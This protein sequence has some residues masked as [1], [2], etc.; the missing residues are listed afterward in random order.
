MCECPSVC[1]LCVCVSDVTHRIGLQDCRIGL[2]AIFKKDRVLGFL[3]C[4]CKCV[5]FT[6]LFRFVGW[7][8]MI[9]MMQ[10]IWDVT[11]RIG[12]QDC[13]I[14]LR[15]IFKKDRVLGFLWCFCKCVFSLCCSVLLDDCRWLMSRSRLQDCTIALRAIFWSFLGVIV[16][17]R[18]GF[19]T[20][21]MSCWCFDLSLIG[22]WILFEEISV[23]VRVK[24]NYY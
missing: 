5:F 2:R 8:Q 14:V 11:H 24:D 17:V 23:V 19:K 10:M 18:V 21:I 9:E 1:V 15:A 13:K 7:L 12:L 4:F 16:K 22:E 20:Q 6:L 3:W